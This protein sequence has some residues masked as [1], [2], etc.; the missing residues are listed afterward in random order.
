MVLI[1]N[2]LVTA[3]KLESLSLGNSAS[4]ST[5]SALV[6]SKGAAQTLFIISAV[7]SS[8]FRLGIKE[9]KGNSFLY[10]SMKQEKHLSSRASYLT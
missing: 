1:H 3:V 10:S 6:H 2:T 7:A 9:L 5:F 4:Q 8:G